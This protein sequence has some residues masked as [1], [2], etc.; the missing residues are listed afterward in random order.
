MAILFELIWAL[1]N[2]I[3]QGPKWPGILLLSG[4][5]LLILILGRYGKNIRDRT[6]STLFKNVVNLPGSL[7]MLCD[8]V[9]LLYV[10]KFFSWATFALY[11]SPVLEIVAF[12]AFFHRAKIQVEH[13]FP[14]ALAQTIAHQCFCIPFA[15]ITALLCGLLERVLPNQFVLELLVLVFCYSLFDL[16]KSK[17]M[18]SKLKENGNY[19]LHKKLLW[20]FFASILSCALIE[21][22]FLREIRVLFA[23]GIF[24]A[25]AT[26]IA[27]LVLLSLGLN[28][29]D[30]FAITVAILRLFSYTA[31]I[32]FAIFFTTLVVV[33]VSDEGMVTSLIT[34]L[35]ILFSATCVVI[36]AAIFFY[37]LLKA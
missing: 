10:V 36:G 33:F 13:P 23:I 8:A 35:A 15:L 1:S 20:I 16:W 18:R 3:P 26:L 19:I 9:A 31:V 6:G 21:V 25:V 29:Y 27:S 17:N 12:I 11:L 2:L 22:G 24:A 7:M 5:I 4:Y 30:K 28:Q 32:L 34:N 37:Y 14:L